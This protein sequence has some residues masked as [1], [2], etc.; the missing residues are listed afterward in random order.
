MKGSANTF[1]II[2][3]GDIRLQA[4]PSRERHPDVFEKEIIEQVWQEIQ[5]EHNGRFFNGSCFN[6]ID[7]FADEDGLVV[8][9]EFVEYK[10]FLVHQKRND[11][12]LN[13]RPIA[14]SG[15]TIISEG[16][17]NYILFAERTNNVTEYQGLTELVPSG[18]LS[19]DCLDH[20]GIVNFKLQLLTELQEE[21]GISWCEVTEV[22]AFAFV[23]DIC[24]HVFDIGCIIKAAVAKDLV[25]E[26]MAGLSEYRTPVFVELSSLE[27]FARNYHH[28]IVPSSLALI[29]AFGGLYGK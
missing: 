2:A 26:K 10:N 9:G 29:Q 13:I 6:F 19:S 7:L 25:R 20:N 1:E 17:A 21:T 12:N 11:L 4:V 14:V 28:K 18:G 15:F 8:E 22:Q 3:V 23:K 5:S 24:H 16:D 27:S